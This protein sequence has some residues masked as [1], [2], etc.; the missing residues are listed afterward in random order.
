MI[1]VIKNILLNFHEINGWKIVENG[2]ESNELFF[3]RKGL[4]MDRMKK[5]HHYIV[6]VYKNFEEDGKQYTGSSTTQ[7]HP[8]MNEVEIKTAISDAAFAAG[9]VKNEYYPLTKPLPSKIEYAQSKFSEKPMAAFMPILT[10]AVYVVDNHTNGWINSTEVFLNKVNTRIVNSEGVD[11]VFEKYDG[12][13]EFITDWKEEG[14]EI[15]LYRDIKFSEPDTAAITEEVSHMLDSSREKAIA[16]L[17]PALEKST[18]L[19]TGEPVIEFFSYYYNQASAQMVYNNLSTAKLNENIQGTEVVGDKL[20]IKLDPTMKNSTQAIPYD[21]D[22]FP[23]MPVTLFENGVLLNFVSDVRHAHYLKVSPTGANGNIVVSAGSKAYE[24]LK[25]TK[26]L[27]LTAFSSFEV[28]TLTGNFSGEIRLGWYFN[29]ETSIPVTGGS[30]SGNI[31]EV[32][33]E[34]YLSKELQKE[35]NFIGPQ[36]IQLFNVSVSGC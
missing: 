15:E 3:V 27:E 14:E 30:I 32:H 33:N 4:D 17:T 12:E 11:V 8:T 7:L 34:M 26:N 2:I 13:I 21:N 29:G 10:E 22:G 6:T 19:L 5:V 25:G 20:T 28:D 36:T 9:F 1:E 18:I 24:E 31:K 23:L 16:T 35:N